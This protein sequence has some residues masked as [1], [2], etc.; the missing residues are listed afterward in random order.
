MLVDDLVTSEPIV[1]LGD[2]GTVRSPVRGRVC[3]SSARAGVSL[4]ATTLDLSPEGW[5]PVFQ[6]TGFVVL[7]YGYGEPGI[8]SSYWLVT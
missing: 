8:P 1:L 7:S 3:A 6:I 2:A 4:T 5:S